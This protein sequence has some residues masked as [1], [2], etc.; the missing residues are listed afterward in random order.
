V[1]PVVNEGFPEMTYKD[2]W[3][4]VNL[5]LWFSLGLLEVYQYREVWPPQF[6]VYK[7]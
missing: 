5:A 6:P 1:P 3:E 4:E 2:N 7:R